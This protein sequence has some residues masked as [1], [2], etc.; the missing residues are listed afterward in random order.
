MNGFIFLESDKRK[1]LRKVGRGEEENK[2]E[3][4]FF[5]TYDN[6]NKK[7]YHFCNLCNNTN[8]ININYYRVYKIFV[9]FFSQPQESE[10]A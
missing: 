1:E 10:V 9:V 3:Q 7:Y 2:A 5:Q 6:Y 8:L 4:S